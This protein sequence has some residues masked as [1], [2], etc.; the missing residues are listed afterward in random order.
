MN[1]SI[2]LRKRL[3]KVNSSEQML[4]NKTEGRHRAHELRN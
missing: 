1:V 4:S 3:H 2:W